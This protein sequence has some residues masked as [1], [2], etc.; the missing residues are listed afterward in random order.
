MRHNEEHSVYETPIA[1]PD[2]EHS[3]L[4]SVV[5]LTL[6]RHWYVMSAIDANT[7]E[8][9]C[10]R[11]LVSDPI[12]VGLQ[13]IGCIRLTE[14]TRRVNYK[15]QTWIWPWYSKWRG[16]TFLVWLKVKRWCNENHTAPVQSSHLSC[17]IV[18]RY[19]HYLITPIVARF[20]ESSTV[21]S[22]ISLSTSYSY[23]RHNKLD[24]L[25]ILCQQSSAYK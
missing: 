17:C 25:R 4:W 8:H 6:S 15:R 18:Y 13:L 21:R 16:T 7:P 5:T 3:W 19:H 12:R 1:S 20:D 23:L 2:W 14:V 9:T 10:T 11:W 24:F 22:V